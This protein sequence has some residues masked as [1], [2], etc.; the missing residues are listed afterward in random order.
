LIYWNRIKYGLEEI[1]DYFKWIFESIII[2]LKNFNQ[3]KFNNLKLNIQQLNSSR[4]EKDFI[5]NFMFIVLEFDI[6]SHK[7][8]RLIIKKLRRS[9]LRQQKGKHRDELLR[10]DQN[11]LLYQAWINH[12]QKQKEMYQFKKPNYFIYLCFFFIQ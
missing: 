7:I 1:I 12:L 5:L 9:I 3:T 8:Y 6:L 2:Y 4:K 10:L 11:D